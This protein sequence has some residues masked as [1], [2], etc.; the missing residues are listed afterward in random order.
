MKRFFAAVLAACLVLTSCASFT[1]LSG[2]G[3][4]DLPEESSQSFPPEF[5]SADETLPI[6]RESSS[7]EEPVEM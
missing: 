7:E 6:D 5:P 3:K 4:I 2:E 1:M